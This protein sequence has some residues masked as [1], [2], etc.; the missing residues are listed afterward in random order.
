MTDELE[1]R[2]GVLEAEIEE[3]IAEEIGRPCGISHP[4]VSPQKSCISVKAALS[5]PVQMERLTIHIKAKMSTTLVLYIIY[6]PFWT[7]LQK[8]TGL[9]KTYLS[10]A[11]LSFC[12]THGFPLPSYEGFRLYRDSL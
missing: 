9:P 5:D 1:T 6:P 2:A 11:R 12:R 4:K 7:C 3:G 8:T 10:V